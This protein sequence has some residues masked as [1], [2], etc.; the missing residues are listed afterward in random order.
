MA[1]KL[2]IIVQGTDKASGVLGN[3]GKSAERMGQQMQRAGKMMI[4]AGTAIVGSLIAITVKTAQAGDQIAKMAKRTGFATETLSELKHAADLSG[5]SLESLE[6]SI[7]RMQ[8]SILNAADGLSTTV[9]AFDRLGLSID[10]V[11]GLDPEEQFYVLAKAIADL[12]DPTLRAAVAQEIFGRAGT[13][14]LPMLSEGSEGLERMR[15][16]AHELGVVFDEEAAKKAEEFTD[17]VTRLKTSLQ[18]VGAE[19]GMELMPILTE[20]LE[21]KIIPVITKVVAWIKENEGLVKTLFKVGV[22]L[23]GAGG[24]IFAIGQISKTIMA[25]NAA[26]AIM[27]GLAGP[28]GWA[29]MAAGIGIAAGTILGMNKLMSTATTG[30]DI[31][32]AQHGG[33]ATRR[34]VVE[35]AEAH[36]E[37]IIPLPEL[38]GLGAGD[39]HIH[40]GFLVGD[41]LTL[42]KFARIVKERIQRDDRRTAFGPVNQGYYYGRSST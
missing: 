33:I 1:N 30:V 12:E 4:A 36:P 40:V 37:A 31:P 39:V 18:K 16:E 2:E 3:I 13:D 6:S 42:N 25:V 20:L 22:A 7:K 23:I 29:K 19:I 28:A 10:D 8:R 26:L 24:V 15:Q 9:R 5:T 32:G 41:E 14:L 35:V 34:T 21:E 27:H 38:A 11:M 17:A